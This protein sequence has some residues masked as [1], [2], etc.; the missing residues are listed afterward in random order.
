MRFFDK[1]FGKKTEKIIHSRYTP[2][3]LIDAYD[4]MILREN[5]TIG[6]LS[7][8]D[9]DIEVYFN[10]PKEN[11]NALMKNFFSCLF[12]I[13]I[14]VQGG[15]INAYSIAYF[16]I[17]DDKITI[18]YWGNNE[19]TE[20]DVLVYCDSENWYCSKIG[21]KEYNPPRIY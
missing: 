5:D 4:K 14:M 10:K 19:N 3:L 17:S 13:D 20:F 9:D 7:V 2:E 11:A 12:R 1:R 8:F 18:G 6:I 15:K 16:D 21:M